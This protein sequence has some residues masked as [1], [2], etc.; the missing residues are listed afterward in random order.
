MRVIQQLTEYFWNR[1]DLS[2]RQVDYLVLQGYANDEYLVGRRDPAPRV[3]DEETDPSREALEDVRVRL[4]RARPRVGRGQTRHPFSQTKFERVRRSVADVLTQRATAARQV[5]RLAEQLEHD[6]TRQTWRDFAPIAEL[7]RHLFG[8]GLQDAVEAIRSQ[9]R[10]LSSSWQLLDLAEFAVIAGD[11]QQHGAASNALRALLN[12]N[13]RREMGSYRWILKH[14]EMSLVADLVETRHNYLQVLQHLHERSF[15]LLHR[16]VAVNV[17]PQ[18]FW[19]L[20]LT[21]N[22]RQMRPIARNQHGTGNYVL[23]R[24]PAWRVWLQA[25]DLARAID[26]KAMDQWLHQIVTDG[27]ASPML[28]PEVVARTLMLSTIE[29]PVGWHAPTAT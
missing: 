28:D 13:H 22:A 8:R 3:L 9:P 24:R 2:P 21:Y 11:R 20:V 29:C 17:Q 4:D 16:A 7:L 10:L 25:I 1:G 18:L 14:G 19:T 15:R 23:E 5:L 26:A 12:V 27:S 6:R